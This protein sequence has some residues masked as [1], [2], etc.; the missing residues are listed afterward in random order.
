MLH[1]A[2]HTQFLCASDWWSLLLLAFPVI[3]VGIIFGDDLLG[4]ALHL[5]GTLHCTTHYSVRTLHCITSRH[6]MSR[7]VTLHY[8]D[9][10]LHMMYQ[11]VSGHAPRASYVLFQGL[12]RLHR[13]WIT[14]HTCPETLHTTMHVTWENALHCAQVCRRNLVCVC[15]QPEANFHLTEKFQ[16]MSTLKWFQALSCAFHATL[17][18]ISGTQHCAP[19][20]ICCVVAG[21]FRSPTSP[22]PTHFITLWP[23]FNF[24]LSQDIVWNSTH[25]HYFHYTLH[26]IFFETC[27]ITFPSANY[28]NMRIDTLHNIFINKYIYTYIIH[29]FMVGKLWVLNDHKNSELHTLQQ[30]CIAAP[31]VLCIYRTAYV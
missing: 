8:I 31:N 27:H 9:Q 3:F 10:L 4:S 17:H 20:Q 2:L 11:S 1:F 14:W 18:N 24:Q 30:H 22:S 15:N 23:N 28:S 6:T 7:H 21:D 13:T 25:S 16:Q 12:S 19:N 26:H 5:L 29:I